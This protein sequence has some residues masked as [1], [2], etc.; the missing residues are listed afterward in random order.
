MP[1]I[2][3]FSEPVKDRAA[4]EEASP[5]HVQADRG[6]PWSWISDEEVHFR[7]KDFW[8]AYTKVTVDVELK[9]VNAGRVSGA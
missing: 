8:P 5:S 6:R 9:D 2:V 1:I 3:R 7:P 4:V